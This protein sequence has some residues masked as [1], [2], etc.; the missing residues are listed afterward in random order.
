[1]EREF[2]TESDG[3]APVASTMILANAAGWSP[4]LRCTS[5]AMGSGLQNEGKVEPGIE[6]KIMK[7]YDSDNETGTVGKRIQN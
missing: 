5:C 3:Y 4:F 6:P 1:M 2:K 7:A